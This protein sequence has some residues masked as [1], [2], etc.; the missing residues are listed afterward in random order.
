MFWRQYLYSAKG[1]FSSK[2]A[3]LGTTPV[4]G[5]DLKMRWEEIVGMP[6]QVQEG[7]SQGLRSIVGPWTGATIPFRCYIGL[8][9]WFSIKLMGQIREIF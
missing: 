7:M 3:R 1:V 6:E 2:Q 8:A 4:K 5:N 9:T